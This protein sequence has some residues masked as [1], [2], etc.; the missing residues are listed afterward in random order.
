MRQATIRSQTSSPRR[1]RD[2][3]TGL[4]IYDVRYD[5]YDDK[6]T[7]GDESDDEY[8]YVV[9]HYVLTDTHQ[10]DASGGQIW[11][12]G[13]ELTRL[14][15]WDIGGLPCTLHDSCDGLSPGYHAVRIGVL[16]SLMA[17][18][19]TYWFVTHIKDAHGEH[20]RNGQDRWALDLNGKTLVTALI[21]VDGDESYL[22]DVGNSTTV[23][24]KVVSALN[25]SHVLKES[26]VPVTV[27]ATPSHLVSTSCNYKEQ[28]SEKYPCNGSSKPKAD[29]VW[30][31]ITSGGSTTQIEPDRTEYN[32]MVEKT[33]YSSLDT[34]KPG[35]ATTYLNGRFT[36]KFD[37]FD[38]GGRV[39]VAVLKPSDPKY[40]HVAVQY[41]DDP[42]DPKNM[43]YM[44]VPWD[45]DEDRLPDKWEKDQTDPD[46][47]TRYAFDTDDD[48]DPH[49][50][51]SNTGD[52]LYAF[53]EYRGFQCKG[54]WSR[55]DPKKKDLFI[56]SPVGTGNVQ[57]A[58]GF[59]V[60]EVQDGND[61][62]M[63]DENWI[64]RNCFAFAHYDYGDTGRDY[65]QKGVCI[66]LTDV[67]LPDAP[68]APAWAKWGTPNDVNGVNHAG[69]V[70]IHNGNAQS[71]ANGLGVT[72]DAVRAHI[73]THEVAH[74]LK[75]TPTLNPTPGIG[76]HHDPG[77]TDCAMDPYISLATYMHNTYCADCRN[78]LTLH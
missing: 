3:E 49:T 7:E 77:A 72:L 24:V 66:V 23:D 32:D 60:H 45:Y 78:S 39:K 11:L 57:A 67:A 47:L 8:I 52:G 29:F 40:S 34:G 20:Y 46:S 61:D 56:R 69:C 22:P 14:G 16:T 37:S 54:S 12:Y 75:L 58:T 65:H 33:I 13:P 70:H 76:H 19:G 35:N 27:Q 21:I 43:T 6:G 36:M 5:G 4:P 18:V 59:A 50:P 17:D 31:E 25:P 42:H 28:D 2:E 10:W 74:S 30:K 68:T 26:R 53:E 41:K 71:C 44:W 64:T 38:Y 15:S 9:R 73:I 1:A 63:S 48:D 62:E 51:S 55:I